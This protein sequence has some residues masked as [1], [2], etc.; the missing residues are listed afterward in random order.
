MLPLGGRRDYF[1]CVFH[2]GSWFKFKISDFIDMKQIKSRAML[3]TIKVRKWG[4]R[5]FSIT[6]LLLV[7]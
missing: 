2:I 5:L 4:G 7:L 1:L 6:Y 3:C